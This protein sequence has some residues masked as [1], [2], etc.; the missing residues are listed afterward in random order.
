MEMQND[1]DQGDLQVPSVLQDGEQSIQD[2]IADPSSVSSSETA[3]LDADRADGTLASSSTFTLSATG[4]VESSASSIFD[5]TGTMVVGSVQADF[6]ADGVPGSQDVTLNNADS[7][8][9][10]TY[11]SVDLTDGNSVTVQTAFN[12]GELVASQALA[13]YNADGSLANTVTTTDLE[14]ADNSLASTQGTVTVGAGTLADTYTFL[15]TENGGTL[16]SST[17]TTDNANGI[18]VGGRV[19]QLRLHHR[20]RDRCHLHRL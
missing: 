2:F 16:S 12:T 20:R 4:V 9:A 10:S 8:L 18:E 14:A 19:G 3:T 7:T 17:T 1:I 15:N 13:I 5:A 11:N 6:L